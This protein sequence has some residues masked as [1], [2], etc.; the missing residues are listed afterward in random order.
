M[1]KLFLLVLISVCSVF[2]INAQVYDSGNN[3]GIGTYFPVSKLEIADP[4]AAVLSLST[5][6]LPGTTASPLRPAI[7]FLGYLNGN[8]ARISATEETTN[9]Y[10][11]RFSI[12]VNDGESANHMVERLTIL[13]NGNVGIGTSSPHGTFEIAN[14]LGTVLSLS[15]DGL[16]GTTASPLRPAINFLGYLNGNKARISA[17][18]ETT[19]TYGSRFSIYVNDGESA[20]HMVER[21]TILPNG[22]V[23]IGTSSPHGTFEIANPLGTV[24]SLSTD[25]LPGTTASPL[26]P[27]INFL[28]YLNGNKARISAT[29]ETTNTY[30]SRF[31]IYVNDGESANHMVERLTILPNGY[32]GIGTFSPAYKLDVNGT[33]RASEIK[34]DLLGADFVFESN[35][36]LMPLNELEKYVTENK[37]LPKISTAKEMQENGTDL[38]SLNTSLLQKIEEL[39][40]YS[41]EQDKR[42][43]EL[44]KQCVMIRTLS[45][46]L[47]KIESKSRE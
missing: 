6:G 5:D 27:A 33:I 47:E 3:V 14:P 32:I 20:N 45:A 17:T 13:P 37:H 9:T 16:P 38:G 42:I 18:E 44:E 43:V 40:L 4:T 19:N 15:T 2:T 39:T 22:N 25:G 24:L 12:Y 26:R 28:G 35:Y 34:V 11:S 1:K 31:S 36:K 10:G 41:I 46:K 21:L 29:E 30:G 23:G 8:K 7:N